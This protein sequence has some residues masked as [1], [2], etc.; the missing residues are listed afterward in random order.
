MN[1]YDKKALEMAVWA[2]AFAHALANYEGADDSLYASLQ[3]D[4]AVLK[5]ADV[6]APNPVD[7]LPEWRKEM[8]G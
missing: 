8:M 1:G 4:Q 2:A 5:L 3:A 7:G 6:M